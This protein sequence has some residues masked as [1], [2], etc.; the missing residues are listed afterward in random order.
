VRPEPEAARQPY[1]QPP[2]PWER[3]DPPAATRRNF[4]PAPLPF[5]PARDT[6]YEPVVVLP[7]PA[8]RRPRV[9]QKHAEATARAARFVA[10]R[11][12]ETARRTRNY[13]VTSDHNHGLLSPRGAAV[14]KAAQAYGG[15]AFPPGP[16]PSWSGPP[17]A[18]AQAV[19]RALAKGR[20]T[21]AQDRQSVRRPSPSLDSGNVGLAVSLVFILFLEAFGGIILFALGGGYLVL[22]FGLALD[23]CARTLGTVAAAG[24]GKGWGGG[25]RWACAVLGSPAVAA[26]AF[27]EDGSL[28]DAD[29][30]PLAGPVSVLAIICVVIGLAGIPAGI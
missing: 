26:F 18:R 12:A 11:A 22:A 13:E 29:L 24:A 21:L 4:V 19:E 28:V 27:Y 9:G 17:N 14:L 3:E 6:Y 23:A 7:E 2:S 1:S 30:A 15:P 10:A 25:W 5:A 16:T 20:A 8:R